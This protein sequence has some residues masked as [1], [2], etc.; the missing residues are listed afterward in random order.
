V[1]TLVR[2]KAAERLNIEMARSLLVMLVRVSR[3]GSRST[4]SSDRAVA[5]EESQD[6]RVAN[7]R[8]FWSRE[9]SSAGCEPSRLGDEPS[10]GKKRR[11]DGPRSCVLQ[12]SDPPKLSVRAEAR[13]SSGPRVVH[14]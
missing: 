14:D 1:N 5:P 7:K 13:D 4:V 12:R 3:S 11:H 9:W 10:V 2:P 6:R 8:E